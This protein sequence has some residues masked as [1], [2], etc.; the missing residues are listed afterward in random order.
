VDISLNAKKTGLIVLGGGT[1]KHFALNSQIFRDG[2]D[3]AV[4]VNTGSEFDGSDSG[5]CPNEAISWGKI[6]ADALSVK[7]NGDA[8][9]LFP[10]IVAGVLQGK[11][12]KKPKK[13]E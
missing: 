2:C 12:T 8:T 5:A 13:D 1:A 9:I 7:V 11:N 4:Y 6:K 3:Y 10:L